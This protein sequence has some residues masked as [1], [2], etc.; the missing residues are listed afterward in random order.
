MYV[1]NELN[2]KRRT[3]VKESD[4]EV[5]WLQV[6]PLKSK[7]NILMAAIY[8][9]PNVMCKLIRN[10]PKTLNEYIIML[11]RETILTGDFN[12]DWLN[13]S[14]KK[15][16]LVKAL[17]DFKFT[18]LVTTVTRPAI[19]SCLDHI[20]SNAPARIVN[21]VCPN[22]AIC[23]FWEYVRLYKQSS[24]NNTN[25]HN[26]IVYRNFKKLNE[27]EFLKTLYEIHWD[28]AFD[29]EEVDDVIVHGIILLMM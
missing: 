4:L 8:R 21:I 10:W 6:C 17:K 11:N 18:Q 14:Y 9:P 16:R 5:L 24:L 1:N 12:I 15:H 26:Y 27:D 22:F 29:F 23:L 28:S 3:D 13:C 19:N 20:W 25:S 7:R 2:I